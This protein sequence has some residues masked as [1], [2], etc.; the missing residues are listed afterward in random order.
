[1]SDPTPTLATRALQEIMRVEDAASQI[2][3]AEGR[4]SLESATRE[5]PTIVFPMTGVHSTWLR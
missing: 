4:I 1:M 3:P 2:T 5:I